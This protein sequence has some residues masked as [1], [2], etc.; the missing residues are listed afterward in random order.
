MS[1][2][3][4]GVSG[5]LSSDGWAPL[6][7]C[8]EPILLHQDEPAACRDDVH[9]AVYVEAP[10][11]EE[12]LKHPPDVTL[13]AAHSCQLGRPHCQALQE[14][15]GQHERRHAKGG[16]MQDQCRDRRTCYQGVVASLV[17]SW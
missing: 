15:I 1:Q 9:A 5:V 2:I 16:E 8:A 13:Q 4:S 12:W 10:R 6:P 17:A 11:C 7:A 14:V 3:A